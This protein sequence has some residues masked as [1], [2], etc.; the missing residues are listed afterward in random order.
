[1]IYDLSAIL[2]TAK[3]VYPYFERIAFDWDDKYHEYLGKILKVKDECE[4]HQLLY[5][6]TE[7][8][9][10]GQTKYIPQRI[11]DSKAI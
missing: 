10:D 6:F 7:C 3:D 1:M 5:Q 8:L 2:Q 11:H 4:F 9:Q